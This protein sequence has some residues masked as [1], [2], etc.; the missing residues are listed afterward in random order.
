MEDQLNK[1]EIEG[2]IVSDIRIETLPNSHNKACNFVLKNKRSK[3]ENYV[4]C[5][6][7]GKNV[8]SLGRLSKGS[9]IKVTGSL[10]S[11]ML[12]S[13]QTKRVT[14]IR[15]MTYDIIDCSGINLKSL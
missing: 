5:A 4:E 8:Q 6:A 10:A 3:K 7:Y 9:T 11:R 12:T 15:V 13:D 1:I 14:Y 2:E